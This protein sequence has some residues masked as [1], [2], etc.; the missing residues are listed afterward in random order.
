MNQRLIS[1]LVLLILN[2][3]L[4]CHAH[5]NANSTMDDR[6]L[7]CEPMGIT[8]IPTGTCV[9]TRESKAK[10]TEMGCICQNP[11]YVSLR[12]DEGY[13]CVHLSVVF[14][15]LRVIDDKLEALKLPEPETELTIY[16]EPPQT[17]AEFLISKLQ[18]LQKDVHRMDRLLRRDA[19][20]EEIDRVHGYITDALSELSTSKVPNICWPSPA[21][22][23]REL[24]LAHYSALE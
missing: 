23:S 24:L 11:E 18:R 8:S 5:R 6:V 10:Q 2:T 9:G 4:G 13:T 16:S 1:I 21:P 14:T 20:Q 17:E 12:T 7:P 15:A 22:T 3:C 19:S